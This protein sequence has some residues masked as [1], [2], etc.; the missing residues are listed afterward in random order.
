MAAI[1]IEFPKIGLTTSTWMP[2]EEWVHLSP[3]AKTAL[4]YRY[5]KNV[6]AKQLLAAEQSS[7]GGR[8]TPNYR[9]SEI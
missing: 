8:N 3:Q 4:I 2:D 1:K 7:G 5:I 6:H 9:W